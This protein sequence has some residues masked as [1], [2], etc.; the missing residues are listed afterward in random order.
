MLGKMGWKG[1]NFSGKGP[2]FIQHPVISEYSLLLCQA[3][4]IKT[5]SSVSS[6][7]RCWS[8]AVLC[9]RSPTMY[10]RS[11]YILVSDDVKNIIS[12]KTSSFHR[13]STFDDVSA[14]CEWKE[15][16]LLYYLDYRLIFVDLPHQTK[17]SWIRLPFWN[18][19]KGTLVQ[20]RG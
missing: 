11:G 4:I 10:P 16:K 13:S 7:P 1:L 3:T 17:M 5:Q 19:T 15:Q 18:K 12:Q 8:R 2:L 20:E 6:P 9:I 14:Y